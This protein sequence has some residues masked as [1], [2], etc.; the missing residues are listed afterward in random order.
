V[1]DLKAQ[2]K[3][4]GKEELHSFCQNTKRDRGESY[5]ERYYR[6]GSS[7]WF[8]E[9]KMN[10]RA[11]VSIN[12]MRAGHF[13]LKASLSRFNIASTAQCECGDGLQMES[14][15]FGDCKLY[16]NILSEN[17]KKEYPKSVTE[18]LRLEEEDLCKASVTSYTKF[19][20]LFKKLNVQNINCI[21]LELC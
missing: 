6:N 5:F 8:R 7:P 14:H 16:K 15:I 3:K 1:A 2:W 9:I 20:H 10:H 17:S 18:L 19:L 12:G 4:K 21:L 13:G 11:L